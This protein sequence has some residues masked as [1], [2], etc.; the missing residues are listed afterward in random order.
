MANFIPKFSYVHPVDGAT[1]ITLTLPPTGDPLREKSATSGKETRS[2]LGKTQYQKNYQ[3][4]TF[5]LNLIFLTV[6]EKDAL[7]KMFDD[8]ASFGKSFSYYPSEDESEFFNVIWPGSKKTFEPKKVIVSGSDFIYD[9][10]IP[11]RVEL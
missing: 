11:L 9:L 10:K 6:T 2:N 4:H 8:Y 5:E 7:E 3:D 1:T